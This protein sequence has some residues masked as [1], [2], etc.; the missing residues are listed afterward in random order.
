M[1]DSGILTTYK[2]SHLDDTDLHISMGKSF[3]A[4]ALSSVRAYAE[5][6]TL[7]FLLYEKMLAKRYYQAHVKAERE[8]L[9]A[10][11]FTRSKQDTTAYWDHEQD[12]LADL[13]RIMLCRCFDESGYPDLFQ[14]CRGLRGEVH[15]CA[16]PNLFITIAPAEWKFPLPYFLQSYTRNLAG[17][18]YL[19]AIHMSLCSVS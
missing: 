12:A 16:F 15:H 13:V 3:T 10:H 11:V 1:T 9:P 18:C 17:G 2:D 14:H 4:K 6:S 8:Q 19:I 7:A 5:N